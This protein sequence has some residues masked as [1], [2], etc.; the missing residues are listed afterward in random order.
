MLGGRLPSVNATP[1]AAEFAAVEI[2]SVMPSLRARPSGLLSV[3]TMLTSTSAYIIDHMSAGGITCFTVAAQD[4]ANHDAVSACRP[5]E[6]RG[7]LPA[8]KL[9]TVPT[10]TASSSSQE[11]E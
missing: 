7:R 9:G 6:A 4:T 2:S 11:N 8:A 3:I 1:H 10:N 5:R